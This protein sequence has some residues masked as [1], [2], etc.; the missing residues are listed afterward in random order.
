MGDG[1]S[2]L[3]DWDR[4]RRKHYCIRTEQGLY[5]LDPALRV[6]S[7]IRGTPRHGGGGGSRG[8]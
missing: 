8:S 4:I 7:Q 1:Q 3:L 5:G 6:A 2:R